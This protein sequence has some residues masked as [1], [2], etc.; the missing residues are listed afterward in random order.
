MQKPEALTT[1]NR[2]DGQKYKLQDALY[3]QS[4]RNNQIT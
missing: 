1:F 2:P 4:V 3:L